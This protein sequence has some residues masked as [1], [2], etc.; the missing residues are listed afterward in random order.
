MYFIK[1]EGLLTQ[2]R[3]GV[4]TW[5]CKNRPRTIFV[6]SV[7]KKNKRITKKSIRKVGN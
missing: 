3:Y 6:D 5:L 7:M 4:R 2:A 1:K